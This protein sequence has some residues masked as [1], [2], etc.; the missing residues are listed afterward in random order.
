MTRKTTLSNIIFVNMYHDYGKKQQ[1]TMQCKS[2]WL[3]TIQEVTCGSWTHQ[4]VWV[5]KNVN[6]NMSVH[7]YTCTSY[8]QEYENVNIMFYSILVNYLV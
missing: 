6:T 4:H 7:T 2:M 5:M 8:F 1:K 3:L